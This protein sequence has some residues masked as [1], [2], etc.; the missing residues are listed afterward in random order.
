MHVYLKVARFQEMKGITLE[1][2]ENQKPV[3]PDTITHQGQLYVRDTDERR[4]PKNHRGLPVYVVSDHFNHDKQTG[5]RAPY[6][7]GQ[8]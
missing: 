7:Q 5:W 8:E 6:W 4:F 2:R 1:F 3:I